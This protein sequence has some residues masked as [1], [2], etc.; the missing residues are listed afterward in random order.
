MFDPK[1]PLPWHNPASSTVF[2]AAAP[3]GHRI[4]QVEVKYQSGYG[5]IDVRMTSTDGRT[6][7]TSDWLAGNWA[8][9]HVVFA[10][11]ALPG[12][13]LD[14]LVGREQPSY[15]LVNVRFGTRRR[16]AS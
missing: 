12:F 14:G 11:D 9:P 1:E 7:V 2:E 4:E 13:A 8:T 10:F 15:G 6:K 5:M 3:P 16:A